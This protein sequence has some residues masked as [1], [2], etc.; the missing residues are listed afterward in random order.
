MIEQYIKKE[1][2]RDIKPCWLARLV[3]VEGYLQDRAYWEMYENYEWLS[4]Y[5]NSPHSGY[6]FADYDAVCF[7]YGY[8]KRTM[9]F[10]IESLRFGTGNPEWGAKEG[11]RYFVIKLGERL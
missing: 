1:E 9:T 8:T 4:D 5:V 6:G 2:Y 11:K 7:H 10:E 3:T